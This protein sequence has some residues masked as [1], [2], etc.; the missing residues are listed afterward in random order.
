[1]NVKPN[2][3][4]VTVE[5]DCSLPGKSTRLIMNLNQSETH[6]QQVRVSSKRAGLPAIVASRRSSR[7]SSFLGI[8]PPP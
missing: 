4:D 7:G 3:D 5:H 8:T 2:F 6:S 1:L